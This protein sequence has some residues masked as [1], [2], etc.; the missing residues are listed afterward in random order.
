MKMSRACTGML[1]SENEDFK[2]LK[3]LQKHKKHVHHMPHSSGAHG[4][5]LSLQTSLS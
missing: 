2:F 1:S 4:T 5:V 3:K